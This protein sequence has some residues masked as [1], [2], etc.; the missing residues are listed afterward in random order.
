MTEVNQSWQTPHF[1]GEAF[2]RKQ[3]IKI[4]EIYIQVEIEPLSFEPTAVNYISQLIYSKM[5][6]LKIF[7]FYRGT[8][9]NKNIHEADRRALG[10]HKYL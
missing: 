2:K 7:E 5:E 6:A 4:F 3:V 8:R 10:V 1:E 9:I